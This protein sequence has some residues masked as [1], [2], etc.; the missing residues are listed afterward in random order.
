MTESACLNVDP[1]S[2][3]VLDVVFTFFSSSKLCVLS[4]VSL[5][6]M[7]DVFVFGDFLLDERELLLRHR[8]VAI[9]LPPKPF[10]VL[11]LLVRRPERLVRRNELLRLAWPSI[12]VS[13]ATLSQTIWRIRGALAIGGDLVDP[14]Q[15]VARVGYRFV[16]PVRRLPRDEPS[17]D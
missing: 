15:T 7:D 6:G 2:L 16:A 14:I 3:V 11:V 13:D 8:G 12:C 9:P 4:V 17:P 5:P 1:S 10:A